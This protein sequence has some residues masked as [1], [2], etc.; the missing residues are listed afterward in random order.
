MIRRDQAAKTGM[1]G[2]HKGM[3]FSLNC[4]VVLTPEESE[5]IERYKASD[6]VLAI[7]E[8]KKDPDV[9]T[10]RRLITGLSEEQDSVINLLEKEEDIKKACGNFKTLLMVMRSFGGEEVVDF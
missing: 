5:I 8:T 4:R 2:G 6:Q 10:I 3:R 1:F 9:I 7:W